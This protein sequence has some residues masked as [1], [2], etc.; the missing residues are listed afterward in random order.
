MSTLPP[1]SYGIRSQITLVPYPRRVGALTGGPPISRHW[2][3]SIGCELP[4][5][6]HP[7]CT[8]I[9]PWGVDSAP[10]LAELVTPARLPSVNPVTVT[11]RD[12]AAITDERYSF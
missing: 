6:Q 9:R 4:L 12:L 7:Q 10:Y 3:V 1:S 11:P 8:Q 5:D 2:I